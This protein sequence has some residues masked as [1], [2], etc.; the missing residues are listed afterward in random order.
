LELLIPPEVF[1]TVLHAVDNH[2]TRARR[3]MPPA[4]QLGATISGND[5]VQELGKVNDLVFDH[6]RPLVSP[7][8]ATLSASD[9][10]LN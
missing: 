5:S 8:L 9:S 10:K 7:P 1:A 6:H 3:S 4:P 2:V